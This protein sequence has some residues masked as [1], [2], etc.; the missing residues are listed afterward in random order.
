MK[1]EL[2]KKCSFC[3]SS[4]SNIFEEYVSSKKDRE[5]EKKKY[6]RYQAEKHTN[7]KQ[8]NRIVPK[9]VRLF[10]KHKILTFHVSVRL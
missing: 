8:K 7:T 9:I 3:R 5:I 1:S 4:L 6:H 2:L 10:S